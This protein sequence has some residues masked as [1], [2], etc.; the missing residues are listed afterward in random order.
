MVV[1]SKIGKAH[2]DVSVDDYYIKQSLFFFNS[3]NV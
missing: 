1:I 3:I 2:F